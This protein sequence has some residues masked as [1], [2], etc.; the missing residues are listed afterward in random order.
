MK[1]IWQTETEVP[2]LVYECISNDTLFD[3][4]HVQNSLLS[5][6]KRMKIALETAN[7][8]AY[9]HFKTEVPI[10]HRDIKSS[11]VLLDNNFTA[12]IADFGASR[13]KPIDETHLTT[14]V[15]G[16]L[17]YLDPEYFHTSQLTDRSDVYS[18]GVVLAELITGR[19]SVSSENPEC[20]RNLAKLFVTAVNEEGIDKILDD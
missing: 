17:G 18:F 15:Q 4:I 16:T 20:E 1:D 8:L 11:N 2:L 3:Q 14:L 19:K 10:L 7:G 12:K 9:L 5:W 6:E 13:L